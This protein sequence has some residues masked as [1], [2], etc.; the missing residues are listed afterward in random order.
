MIDPP[1]AA[2]SRGIPYLQLQNTL[3]V[4]ALRR[5]SSH[6]SVV[7]STSG[8]M[9]LP[10]STVGAALL[11]SVV[12]DPNR[13]TTWSITEATLASWVTSSAKNSASPPSAV[14]RSTTF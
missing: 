12:N 13:S 7:T 6:S 10:T 14:M 8:L 9:L 3:P 4:S 1:P 2:A 5:I 11:T